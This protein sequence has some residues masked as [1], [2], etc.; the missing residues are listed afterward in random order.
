M[1]DMGEHYMTGM[2]PYYRTKL[3]IIYNLDC[4]IGKPPPRCR[5][6]RV[7]PRKLRP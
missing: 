3:P 5:L 4:A 7:R 6:W 2:F 1:S